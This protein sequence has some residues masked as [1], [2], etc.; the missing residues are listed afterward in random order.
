MFYSFL[1][2]TISYVKYSLF[3]LLN[4]FVCTFV[5]INFKVICVFNISLFS[6]ISVSN[7]HDNWSYFIRFHYESIVLKPEMDQNKSFRPKPKTKLGWKFKNINV[8]IRA[9][10]YF[11]NKRTYLSTKIPMHMPVCACFFLLLKIF[12]FFK[13]YVLK[14]ILYL[15]LLTRQLFIDHE[16]VYAIRRTICMYASLILKELK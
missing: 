16:K 2:S 12:F 3:Y 6:V 13:S 8:Y 15:H 4:H 11:I 9:F 5:F 1:K 14:Y 10:V 7:V